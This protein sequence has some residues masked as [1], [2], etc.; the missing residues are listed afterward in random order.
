MSRG[1]FD[2]LI[3]VQ[4]GTVTLDE[5]GGEV[6]SWGVRASAWARVKFG[7]AQEKREAAQESGTQSATFEVVPTLSLNETLI[8]DRI[9]FDGSFWDI[10]EV[11][12][13]SRHLIRFTAVRVSR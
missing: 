5:H 13:L 4:R 12:P 7:T 6:V 8:K 3:S 10:T 1:E 2:R 11:A 9:E